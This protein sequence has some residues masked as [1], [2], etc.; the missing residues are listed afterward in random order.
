MNASSLRKM[1]SR[2]GFKTED[3]MDCLLSV[4]IMENISD[5]GVL[6]RDVPSSHR[7]LESYELLSRT[8]WGKMSFFQ[9]TSRGRNVGR[10]LVEERLQSTYDE[11]KQA[12]LEGSYLIMKYLPP[13]VNQGKNNP[14]IRPELKLL[15]S[16]PAVE[17]AT[18]QVRD[19]LLEKGLAREPHVLSP[20]RSDTAV[21]TLPDLFTYFEPLYLKEQRISIFERIIESTA[22]DLTLF[23]LLY[24]YEPKAQQIYVKKLRQFKFSR[25]DITS[26][27]HPLKQEGIIS[28]T[29]SDAGSFRIND[30]RAYMRF[31]KEKV[32]KKA[33]DKF[34][35]TIPHE[36]TSNPRAYSVLADFEEDFREF[37][38]NVLKETDDSWEC[39]I[40]EDILE[41]LRE[42]QHDADIRKK[43]VYPL[44]H[45]IDFP[46]YLSIILHRAPSFNN[47]EVFEP[48]FIS[49]GWIKARL[50]EMNEIRNDLAHPKPLES[51]QYRKLQLYIDEIRNRMRK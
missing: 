2:Y 20:S 6:A 23:R 31:L 41:R 36:I 29:Y 1:L 15:T 17:H 13:L 35:Q 32:L 27:L 28:Y 30:R 43:T 14:L 49:I 16:L 8:T 42:R 46:N 40:P 18:L 44:L 47:W 26:I 12:D 39:R 19:I 11:L 33:L 24:L 34:S 21:V 37:I 50:I 22:R 10:E 4:L 3:V 7:V 38:E 45:Y 9:C 25:E 48:Y 51:L 5:R